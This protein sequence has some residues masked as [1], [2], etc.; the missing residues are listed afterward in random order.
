MRL[1][2]EPGG[3]NFRATGATEEAN[4]KRDL[5]LLNSFFGQLKFDARRLRPLS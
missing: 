2:F 1:N 4:S 5:P 3:Q